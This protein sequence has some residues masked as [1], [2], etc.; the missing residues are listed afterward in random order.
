MIIQISPNQWINISV[1]ES[2]EIRTVKDKEFYLVIKDALYNC[3]YH[4]M[5]FDNIDVA[6][7]FAKSIV[8]KYCH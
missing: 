7:S 5:S 8:T 1:L 3:S 4:S 6:R 2:L